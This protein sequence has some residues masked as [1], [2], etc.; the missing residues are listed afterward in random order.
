MNNSS[1]VRRQ[2]MEQFYLNS[3]KIDDVAKDMS[4]AIVYFKTT[5][6]THIAEEPM[7]KGFDLISNIGGTMGLFVGM[8][9]LSICELFQLVCELTAII[10]CKGKEIK[11]KQIVQGIA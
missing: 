11:V 1:S 7:M 2:L 9:L 10:F 4:K 6:V 8:S 5:T 3:S